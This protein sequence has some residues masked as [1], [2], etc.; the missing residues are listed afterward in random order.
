MDLFNIFRNGVRRSCLQWHSGYIRMLRSRWFPKNHKPRNQFSGIIWTRVYFLNTKE[1]STRP[2]I[3]EWLQRTD[4]SLYTRDYG[5]YE[6]PETVHERDND[7]GKN[8]RER[9]KSFFIFRREH[10]KQNNIMS[11]VF[12]SFI[13]RKCIV[14]S[15]KNTTTTTPPPPCQ[16]F[17]TH[18]VHVLHSFVVNETLYLSELARTC[19]ETTI[20]RE[21]WWWLYTAKS[22]IN[23]LR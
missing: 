10:F 17:L 4:I 21:K 16:I 13:P 1:T 12:T 15:P 7:N 11:I 20:S 3:S 2:R 5:I 23:E 9:I 19:R 8:T 22:I 18:P 14:V 6:R